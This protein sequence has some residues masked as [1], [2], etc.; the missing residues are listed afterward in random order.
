MGRWGGHTMWSPIWPNCPPRWTWWPDH[1]L[2][3]SYCQLP[4]WTTHSHLACSV[5]WHWHKDHFQPH[6]HKLGNIYWQCTF[7]LYGM[8][9]QG[10]KFDPI[11]A[12]CYDK[13]KYVWTVTT[14]LGPC[15]KLFSSLHV[16]LTLCYKHVISDLDSIYI[17]LINRGLLEWH[18]QDLGCNL[19]CAHT[20]LPDVTPWLF[21]NSFPLHNII[22][23]GWSPDKVNGFELVKVICKGGFSLSLTR[24]LS[25]GWLE[26]VEQESGCSCF[27]DAAMPILLNDH[28]TC[29]GNNIKE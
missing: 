20:S 7:T 16:F 8:G 9:F 4:V 29:F 26:P 25:S 5:W 21:S 28:L 2:H 10:S 22:R 11:S 15:E 12:I 13:S 24:R 18:V 3:L 23:D 14:I 19:L 6:S 27:C 1:T 17:R